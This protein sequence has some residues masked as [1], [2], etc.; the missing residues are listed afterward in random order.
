MSQLVDGDDGWPAEEVGVWAKDKHAY[1]RC[2]LEMSKGARRQFIDGRAHSATFIDLFCGP[3]R[4]QIRGT[5]EW[6][7]GSAVAAWKISRAT[8]S[9]FTAIYVADTDAGRRAACVERLRRLDAPVIEMDCPTDEASLEF[10]QKVNP[11]GLNFAFID[12]YSLGALNFNI[13]K[14]LASLKRIDMLIHLSAMDLRRNAGKNISGEHSAFDQFAPGWR[15]SVSA[16]ASEKE[17]R[18]LVVEYW[19]DLVAGL[20]LDPSQDVKMITAS[21]NQQLYWL[22]LVA[23]H[24]LAQK[25][26]KAAVNTDKQGTLF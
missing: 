13:L 20:G 3:G 18:R 7:D 21:Q 22:L 23:K 19:R 17:I 1:L 9:P 24:E 8:N 14:N 5:G 2:Y 25:F 11:H 16:I 26:W 10:T 4:A 12:P 15:E 6:V